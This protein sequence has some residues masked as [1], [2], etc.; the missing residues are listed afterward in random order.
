[1]STRI[2]PM[3]LPGTSL[4]SLRLLVPCGQIDINRLS[5]LAAGSLKL[6]DL[7]FGLPAGIGDGMSNYLFTAADDPVKDEDGTWCT[8]LYF[9]PDRGTNPPS[10]DAT[11]DHTFDTYIDNYDWPPVLTNF[12]LGVM[13]SGA[14]VGSNPRVMPYNGDNQIVYVSGDE[15]IQDHDWKDGYHGPTRV[16]VEQWYSPVK[17]VLNDISGTGA[18]DRRFSRMHGTSVYW[19]VHYDKG[20]TPPCLHGSVLTPGL[21]QDRST[22]V[23]AV[24]DLNLIHKTIAATKFTDWADHVIGEGQRFLNGMWQRERRTARVP[25]SST[26]TA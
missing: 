11:P 9:G 15:L 22:E 4:W 7:E 23:P 16:T 14:Y 19:D 25:H 20:R 13:F 12:V 24:D 1:M 6:K 8:P 18:S 26:Y 5:H 17:W 3:Q 10:W 21:Y 2:L